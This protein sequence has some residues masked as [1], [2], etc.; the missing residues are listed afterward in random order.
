M[1]LGP[2]ILIID[3]LE[4]DFLALGALLPKD[5][6]DLVWSKSA[7]EAID[8]SKSK[9]FALI[10]L[11]HQMAETDGFEI[12][13]KLKELPSLKNTPVVFN[14]V[15]TLSRDQEIRAYQLGIA[16][17]IFM[18]IIA[19]ALDSKLKIFIDLF[20]CRQTKH[21]TEQVHLSN[22]KLAAQALQDSEAQFRNFAN[23]MPQLAWISRADGFVFWNNQGWYDYIGTSAKD[24]EHWDWQS[25]HDPLIPPTVLERWT[26]SIVT[27]KNFDMTFPIKGADGKF[28]SFLTRINPIR[29]ANDKIVRWF[30]TSTDIEDNV[31]TQLKITKVQQE[32]TNEKYKLEQIFHSATA[33]KALWVGEN[34]VFEKVNSKY[35][36]LFPN[37]ELVG[38]T[39]FEVLPELEEQH[40]ADIIVN[41]FLTGESFYGDDVL[42]RH[43]RGKDGTIEN[44][45]YDVCYI[46]I[47]NSDGTPYGV[48]YHAID[49]TERFLAMQK[50]KQLAMDL[51]NAKDEAEKANSL[52]SSFLANMSHEIRTPLGAMIGFADLLRDPSLSLEDHDNF[53]NIMARNGE[54]LSTII[55][56]ILDLSKV[57]AGQLTLEY[58]DTHPD[59]IAEDVISLLRLKARE[60]NIA[61][62]FIA[63]STT[64]VS[65]VSDPVRL[66]QILMN[67]VSNAI[68]F[69]FQGSVKVRIFGA[70][71]GENHKL[72]YIEVTDTGI[73]IPPSE[74]DRVFEPFV[75]V[76]GTHTRKFG[77]TG[78]GLALSRQLARKLGGDVTIPKTLEGKGTTFLIKVE[79]QPKKRTILTTRIDR[80][81]STQL[82]ENILN[83]VRVL[84]VE[85]SEDNRMYISFCLNKFGA[86]IDFA[87]DGEAGFKKALGG[88]HDIVLM[89]IQ[90]PVMDGYSATAK[91]R[92]AG[93]RKP[94]IAL[95]AHAMTEVRRKCL[96]VGCTD[97]LPKPINPIDLICAIAKYLRT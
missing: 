31:Q 76:D 92:E 73:G 1:I 19:E 48:Y 37:I 11:N 58:I 66:K 87:E 36:D 15:N 22:E 79:D 84:I 86:I 97:H 70:A 50:L 30:G 61:L 80:N 26:E 54:Q 96:N 90:M 35:Q 3:N 14:T 52:K 46:Q 23:S 45:Y 28:R 72:L 89:D 94:I 81:P 39:L 8:V 63:E 77:G 25:V 91:L 17:I 9:E 34:L 85:D 88:N 64:P 71:E 10:L 55:D 82:P 74:N 57:E 21:E 93:F 5:H 4:N 41:V 18:P 62:E 51:Q 38:K 49:V 13:S 60:K 27:G 20:K 69:T 33:A 53:I 43:R 78:L 83:N 29:D 32:I 67:I 65:I 24:I 68:K 7:Q 2:S 12:L 75:Q 42:A 56:D 44:R 40:F 6:Y 59:I 47:R 95:T 16:D